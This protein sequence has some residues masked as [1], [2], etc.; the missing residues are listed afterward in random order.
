MID[1]LVPVITMMR[2]KLSRGEPLAMVLKA[3]ALHAEKLT[4]NITT[5]E[6]MKD[7]ASA[8]KLLPGNSNFAFLLSGSNSACTR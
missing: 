6:D 2:L 5:P 3:A 7:A 8:A 4:S 1:V